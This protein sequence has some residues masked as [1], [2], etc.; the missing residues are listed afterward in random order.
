MRTLQIQ[1]GSSRLDPERKRAL[2]DDLYAEFAT[3]RKTDHNLIFG[4][5][6]QYKLLD[7][8]RAR[9]IRHRAMLTITIRRERSCPKRSY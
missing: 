3:G 7:R 1:Q 4:A 8:R 9:S 2:D 6:I 5:R